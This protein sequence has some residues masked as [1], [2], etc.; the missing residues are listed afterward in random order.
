M[1]NT[2]ILCGYQPLN[3][4]TATGLARTFRLGLKRTVRD[5]KMGKKTVGN[6]IACLW[7]TCGAMQDKKMGKAMVSNDI[8]CSCAQRNTARL[9]NPDRGAGGAAAAGACAACPQTARRCWRCSVVPLGAACR[10]SRRGGGLRITKLRKSQPEAFA[11]GSERRFRGRLGFTMR[12]FTIA[13][14]N[15]VLFIKREGDHFGWHWGRG[16]EAEG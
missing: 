5:R 1:Y 3:G 2:K 7:R 9:K 8:A 10:K 6:N 4:T 15:C 14:K 13:Y 11:G 16:R 12:C